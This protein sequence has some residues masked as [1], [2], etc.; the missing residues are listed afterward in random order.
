[1]VYILFFVGFI[2]LIKG[3]DILIDG[4]ASIAERYSIP[5]VVIGLTIVAFGSS[6]P[7]FAVNVIASI[8]KNST[9]AFGNI[10]GSNIANIALILGITPIIYPLTVQKSTLKNEIPLLI[11]ASVVLFIMA[12]D[13]IFD[14]HTKS[15]ISRSDGL[16][17]LGFFLIF[18]RYVRHI[19]KNSVNSSAEKYKE[20][21]FWLSGVMVIGGLIGL[22]LGGDWIVNGGIAVA[23]LFHI[24]EDVIGLTIVAIG[25]SLPELATSAVAAHKKN[26][27]IAVGN[28]VGSVLFNILW[29]LGITTTI[30]PMH[31]KKGNNIDLG[32]SLSLIILL[33]LFIVSNKK[34][35]LL[36]VHGILFLMIYTSYLTYLTVINL[37]VG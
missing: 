18:L 9:L 21:P 27:D 10:I 35:K 28:I 26:S 8:Q 14:G 5:H 30:Y 17:L 4:A 15:V 24:S 37:A 22:I 7:E 2:L 13:A 19:S 16:V 33:F 12:N 6:A 20:Y 1:M 31:L 29:V 11:L 25:T 3:A 23:R 32:I 36:R 34:K